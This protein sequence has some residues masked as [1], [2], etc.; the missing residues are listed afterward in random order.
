MH[1]SSNISSLHFPLLGGAHPSANKLNGSDHIFFCVY[2][3]RRS[4]S[5][6]LSLFFFTVMSS[7]RSKLSPRYQ[8]SIMSLFSPIALSHF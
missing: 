7:F 2:K 5:S 6:P 1:I 8:G 3:T 4:L